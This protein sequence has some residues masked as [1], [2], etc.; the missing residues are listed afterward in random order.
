MVAALTLLA[1]GCAADVPSESA[2][3]AT[4]GPRTTP[5]APARVTTADTGLRLDGHSWWPT[6][7]DAYQIG[8]DY[9]ISDGCGAQVDLDAYFAA[10]PAGSLTRFDLFKAIATERTTGLL[11]FTRMDAVFDAARRHDQLILP[12]LSSGEGACEDDTFK[13]RAWY[14][15]DWRTRKIDGM[16]FEQWVTTA[17]SRW[18]SQPS[19]AGWELVGEPEPVRCLTRECSLRQRTCPSDAAEV[20]RGFFDDAGDVVRALDPHRPIFTGLTGGDQCGIVGDDYLTVAG[21]RNADV[22]DYHDYSGEVLLPADRDSGLGRRVSQA[23]SVGKPLVVNEIGMTAG[24]CRS[25]TTRADVI[26]AKIEKQRRL[27]T[28]GALLWAFVPDPREN[29]CTYDIGPD[30]PLWGVVRSAAR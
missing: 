4:S 5:S 14:A 15:D 19:V 16:S 23:H 12:V 9:T 30:D 11:N 22:L 10:L 18:R 3:P 21:S 6:G 20:L 7:F 24:S 8:T 29:E 27:G 26:S 1:V 17:V 25:L 2:P 28:G 13:D